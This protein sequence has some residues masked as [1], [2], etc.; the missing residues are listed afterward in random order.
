MK[1]RT[2][3]K[4]ILICIVVLIVIWCIIHRRVVRAWL[5]GEPIPEPPEWH[6]KCFSKL[7]IKIWEE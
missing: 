7:G 4:I 2:I 1:A 3:L 6:K 5:L